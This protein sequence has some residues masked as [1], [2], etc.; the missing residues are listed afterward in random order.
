[1]DVWFHQE[2]KLN[3]AKQ[4]NFGRAVANRYSGLGTQKS[5]WQHET[6]LLLKQSSYDVRDQQAIDRLMIALD[7]T[8]NKGKVGANAILGVSIFRS[9]YCCWLRWNHFTATLGGSNTKKFN[10]NSMMNIINGGSFECSNRFQEFMIVPAG[11]PHSKE[12]LR[13]GANL[14]HLRKSLKVVSPGTAV[15]D[16]RWIRSLF[17]RN[18]RWCRNYHRCY[19]LLVMFR[20]K[21]VFISLTVHI[22]KFY[23]KE[24]KVYDYTLN[25]KGVRR[26]CFVHH[27]C[28]T[29]RLYLEDYWNKYPIITIEDEYGRKRLGRLEAPYW[30]S[31]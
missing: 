2:L 16:E 4:L 18:W 20:V 6:T 9:S 19:Q 5:C 27:C 28:W 24:R 10:S 13:W 15:V 25:S 31:W 26:S 23:D 8:P 22:I 17:R 3:T 1:M 12:A 11:A 7:G 29:N 30:T 21:N 14:P